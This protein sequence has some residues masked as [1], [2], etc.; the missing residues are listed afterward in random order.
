M[1]NPL[2]LIT[3]NVPR[4]VFI[5]TLNALSFQAYINFKHPISCTKLYLGG[6]QEPIE[7]TLKKLSKSKN[8]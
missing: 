6:V 4:E 7:K 8:I 5:H 3:H 1:I 2:V